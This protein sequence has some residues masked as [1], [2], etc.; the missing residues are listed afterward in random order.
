M[1]VTDRRIG[2]KSPYVVDGSLELNRQGSLSGVLY[3]LS[4][5]QGRPMTLLLVRDV[6]CLIALTSSLELCAVDL[7]LEAIDHEVVEAI[8]LGD[9]G[10][11]HNCALVGKVAAEL[12]VV[13]GNVVVGGLDPAPTSVTC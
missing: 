6:L 11:D 2:S 5:V 7:E 13:D 12:N 4:E 9:V 8:V 1:S 10:L 3:L